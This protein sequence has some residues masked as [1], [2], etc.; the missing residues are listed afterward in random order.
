MD[1]FQ[2][3]GI[4]IIFGFIIYLVYFY[5]NKY[6]NRQKENFEVKGGSK[7]DEILSKLTS[8]VASQHDILLISKYRNKYEA[9][10]ENNKKYLQINMIQIMMQIDPSN[11]SMT[12]ANLKMF[13]DFNTLKTSY[14]NMATILKYVD[15][16]N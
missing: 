13:N 9:I 2:Q 4:A 1:S 10:I 15:E 16:S 3:I 12:D 14:D 11:D 7:T 8:S 5:Y 6:T